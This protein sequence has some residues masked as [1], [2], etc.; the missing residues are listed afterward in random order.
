[1]I[2]KKEDKF[3]RALHKKKYRNLEQKFI[4]EGEKVLAEL[5]RSRLE[6][7]SLYC[8][9]GQLSA[10]EEQFAGKAVVIDERAMKS[11]SLLSNPPGILAVVKQPPPQFKEEKFILYLEDLSDPG[12]VGTI[13]RTAEGFGIKQLVVS[14][15]CTELFSPKVVQASMG[16]LFRLNYQIKEL[17]TL[18]DELK[19]RY[20][21]YSANMDGN[22]LYTAELQTP[23]VLILGSESH[24]I[25]KEA[26]RLVDQELSIPI[27]QELESLNVAIA[28]AIILSEFKRRKL[29]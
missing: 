15:N 29:I 14:P 12:N 9:E 5:K 6:V 20:Q 17:K 26:G 1:M 10:C 21:F 7:E 8:T 4:A 28:N 19:P 25:S 23:S 27:S 13:L 3:I 16:S 22:E 11:I 18:I 2:S 24:G